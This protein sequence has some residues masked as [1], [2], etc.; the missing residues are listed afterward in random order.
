MNET[1]Q[2]ITGI[3][4]VSKA[5]NV[6][7]GY[8]CIRK[9]ANDPTRD[10]DLMNESILDRKSRFL[11]ITRAYSLADG[12][13]PVVEDIKLINERDQP[14]LHYLPLA[15][16]VDNFERGTSKR[17]ICVRLVERQAGMKCVCDIIFLY[18]AKRPPQFYT[19]IGD[20]NGFQLCVKE[21]WVPPLRVPFVHQNS[22]VD[23]GIIGTMNTTKKTD[24]KEMLDGIPFEI[25]PKYLQT[26]SDARND[27]NSVE[28][29]R[30]RSINEIDQTFFYDFALEHSILR[31]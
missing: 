7:T 4:L 6:P 29:F 21:G 31:F 28:K 13:T 20:I 30:P 27:F 12:L 18:R 23:H 15:T 1:D 19:I 2:P 9:V 24:E 8:Q 10:A 25:N 11:C 14:P 5:G 26:I 17:L 3:C 22:S 16:T